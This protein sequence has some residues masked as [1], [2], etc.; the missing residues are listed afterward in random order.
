M[1]L[2]VR[3]LHD[4][5]LENRWLKRA[6]GMVPAWVWVQRQENTYVPA[7]RQAERHSDPIEMTHKINPHNKWWSL[8]TKFKACDL[9]IVLYWL[10]I[11][12]LFMGYLLYTRQF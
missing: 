6:S 9:I 12:L 2:G 7:Q 1:W 8:D 10:P 3:E 5:Q 4:L 11:E